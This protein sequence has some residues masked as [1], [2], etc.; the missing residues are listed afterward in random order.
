MG[1][2]VIIKETK[3]KHNSWCGFGCHTGFVC[4]EW[5]VRFGDLWTTFS[6]PE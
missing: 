2:R 4:K 3:E 1:G 6:C 5:L